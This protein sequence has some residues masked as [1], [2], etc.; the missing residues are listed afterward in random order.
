MIVTLPSNSFPR[1]FRDER[2]PKSLTMRDVMAKPHR[3]TEFRCVSMGVLNRWRRHLKVSTVRC[4]LFR[5]YARN[6]RQHHGPSRQASERPVRIHREG[7]HSGR[8]STPVTRAN[9][10]DH[11]PDRGS[12]SGGSSR[13]SPRCMRQTDERFPADLRQTR[14]SSAPHRGGSPRS[15]QCHCH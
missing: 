10:C 13:P 14:G 8:R 4:I 2:M 7:I 15:R 6:E 5:A 11:R 9:D 3:H 12:A 1:R